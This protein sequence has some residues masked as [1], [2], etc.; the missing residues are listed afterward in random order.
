[1]ND[2]NDRFSGGGYGG[3]YG[4]GDSGGRRGGPGGGNGNGNGKR[5]KFSRF[6]KA[7]KVAAPEEPLDFKNVAYLQKF[8]GPTGKI[9]SR[10]RTGFSGQHQRQLANAIKLARHMALMPFVGRG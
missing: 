1:M 9:A 3:G 7:K 10:R 8:V 6:G 4:G 5:G 2:N